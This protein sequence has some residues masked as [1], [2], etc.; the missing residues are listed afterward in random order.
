MDSPRFQLSEKL[1]ETEHSVLYR[2]FDRGLDC[3]A[4]RPVLL[5]L[6]RHQHPGTPELARFRR[7]YDLL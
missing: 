4:E 5:K 3:T 2:G 6:L 1:S 7:E